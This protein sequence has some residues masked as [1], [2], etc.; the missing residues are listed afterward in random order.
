M[1]EKLAPLL[2]DD[3]Q[4]DEAEGTRVSV[5]QPAPRSDAARAKDKTKQ[6]EDVGVTL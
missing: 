3:H 2:F 6:T 4:R 1:R 5:V